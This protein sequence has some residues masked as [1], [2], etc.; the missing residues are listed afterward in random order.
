MPFGDWQFYVVT[1]VAIA[2][3][4][5][6]VRAVRPPK[7]RKGTKVELT[8]GGTKARRHGGTKGR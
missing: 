5:M 1:A 3:V 2:A 6:L 7:T 8:V 4:W